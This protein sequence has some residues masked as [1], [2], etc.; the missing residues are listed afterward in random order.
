MTAKQEEMLRKLLERINRLDHTEK[1]ITY[2]P[3]SKAA[4]IYEVETT[5]ALYRVEISEAGYDVLNMTW[6]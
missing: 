4:P 2:R 5:V 1:L 6:K 3:A